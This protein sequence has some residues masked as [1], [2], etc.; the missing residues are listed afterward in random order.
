MFHSAHNG[1]PSL[2]DMHH[3]NTDGHDRLPCT[4]LK[5][6]D[7]F[8]TTTPLSYRDISIIVVCCSTELET[9]S[10][11]TYFITDIYGIFVNS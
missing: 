9:Y 6:F 2:K 11:A 5:A 10:D 8:Q 3:W 7:E 4:V 1:N